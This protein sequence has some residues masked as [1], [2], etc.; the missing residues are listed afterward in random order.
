MNNWEQKS[1]DGVTNPGGDNK[2]PQTPNGEDG[3]NHSDQEAQTAD[4]KVTG[5]KI[6]APSKK[7]T[8]G[9]KVQL[10][11]TIS[12]ENATNK[13]VTWKTS[14]SKYATIDKNG[15]L[16][17]KKAGAGKTVTVTATAADGSTVE[18]T[19]NIKIMKHAVKSIKLSAA[20]KSVKAGK[21]ITVKATVKTT[22]KSVNKTLKWMSSN[23]KYATVSKSGKVKTKKAGKGK[24]VTITATSTD[25]TNKKAKIKIKIK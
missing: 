7:L 18:A 11:L 19:Y 21:S 3:N 9:K 25:G 4:I 10:A 24:T 20:S 8:A 16:S 12:P 22:G 13:T 6:T 14:N 23:T 17:I 15:K 1:S 5:L 2:N